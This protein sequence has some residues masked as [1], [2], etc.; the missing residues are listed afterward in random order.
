MNNSK[1]RSRVKLTPPL[2]PPTHRRSYSHAFLSF[3][4]ASSSLPR[5]SRAH[6]FPLMKAARVKASAIRRGS[7]PSPPRPTTHRHRP[8]PAAH[9]RYQTLWWL[10]QGGVMIGMV[11]SSAMAGTTRGGVGDADVARCCRCT[12]E[13]AITARELQQRLRAFSPVQKTIG[14]VGRGEATVSVVGAI[15]SSRS[16]GCW[17]FVEK[18]T[19]LG[20]GD[21][22]RRT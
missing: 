11:R 12:A 19:S 15:R 17:E 2:R 21:A 7:A 13:D 14:S 1:K 9:H 5:P 20:D 8:A 4:P 10:R 6:P 18:K 16:V 22:G 3:S